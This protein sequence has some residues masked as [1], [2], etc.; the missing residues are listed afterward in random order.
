MREVIGL[1][2]YECVFDSLQ[3]YSLCICNIQQTYNRTSIPYKN[4]NSFIKIFTKNL[5]IIISYSKQQLRWQNAN[6]LISTCIHT[7][8]INI[9]FINWIIIKNVVTKMHHIHIFPFNG[10]YFIKKILIF[11]S[12]YINSNFI[13]IIKCDNNYNY[14]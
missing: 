7:I 13:Y 12:K 5:I 11:N 6:F 4:I 14:Y 10:N 9:A 1:L 8:I 3:I 2:D